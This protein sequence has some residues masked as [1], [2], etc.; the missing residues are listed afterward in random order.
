MNHFT[1][2][3]SEQ[4]VKVLV[5]FVHLERSSIPHVL[6]WKDRRSGKNNEKEHLPSLKL[7]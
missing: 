1:P 4:L 2:N 3:N 7:T 5:G 6:G